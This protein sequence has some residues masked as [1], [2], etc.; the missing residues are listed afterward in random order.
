MRV[1]L[2]GAT[3]FIGSHVAHTV[4]ARGHEVHA[5]VRPG[6]SRWRIA[7][8]EDRL[9]VIEGDLDQPAALAPALAAARAD[10]CLHLA[11]QGWSGVGGFAQGNLESV[12]RS[13]NFARAVLQSGCR[14]LLITGTCFEYQVR[15]EVLTEDSPV[16]PHDL[17]GASKHAVH[18]V[19]EQIA[20]LDGAA[21]VWPRIFYT[22]GPY[23][24][25][26]RLVPSVVGALLRGEAAP[27]TAGAQVRDYLHV[28]DV[29]SALWAIAD[30]DYTGAINVASGTAVSLRDLATTAAAF[31]GGADRL[32]FGA[33][34]YRAGEPMVLRA[35]G[36]RLRDVIGWRPAF[37]L[38]SG[39]A[40]TVA[41]WKA[42]QA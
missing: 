6:S 32:Q 20:N 35:S 24:D 15:D 11:W 41:W 2:T 10:I 37:D 1:L 5:I 33:L 16:V 38:R 13:L 18:V 36:G 7:D 3:G 22:F 28:A 40:E 23:E 4:V 25:A 8:I 14:R 9:H 26:R 21:L 30:S 27:M 19:A 17:Y 12:Y 34:P 29:A 42:R 31:A 39:L